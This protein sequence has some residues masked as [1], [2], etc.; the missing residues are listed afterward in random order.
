MQQVFGLL[1]I[2]KLLLSLD[3]IH[4]LLYILGIDFLIGNCVVR[5]L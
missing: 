4:Y 2:K 1:R 3:Q 5:R